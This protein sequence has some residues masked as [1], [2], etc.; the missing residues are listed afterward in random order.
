MSELA[1]RLALGTAQFGLEYGIAN[2][3][4]QV[5]PDEVARIMAV[6]REEGVGTLDTAMS[7]GTSE[8]VLGQV[9]V[10][11]WRVISKLPPLPPAVD[12]KA[13]VSESVRGSL[14]RLR[15]ERLGALL[16]HRPADLL[17]ARADEV[18]DA[19][20]GLKNEGLVEEV[21]ASVYHPQEIEALVG[22]FALDIIQA[23]F[24]VIDRRVLTSGWMTRL[25]ERRV[26]LQVRSAFLQ[27]LL[28][29]EPAKRPPKFRK[30][31][32]LLR[33]WDQWRSENRVSPVAACIAFAM[34]RPEVESVVVGVDCVDQL[35]EIVSG[36]GVAAPSP[37]GD[38]ASEDLDLVDPSR[39]AE[40]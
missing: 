37:P 17:E 23:P 38:L 2:S 8:A 9:G 18:Y 28:L 14:A 7:Y 22:R 3:R 6:A 34:S 19:L 13:W 15:G 31:E 16:L 10:H 1:S 40:R 35:R 36:L 4:G 21:G 30:W 26:T 12:V 24:N 33:G 25:R 20:V 29:L 27:G 11:G 32:V 5:P 39:W